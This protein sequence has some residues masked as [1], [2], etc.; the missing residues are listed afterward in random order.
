VAYADSGCSAAFIAANGGV[1]VALAPINSVQSN[2]I[3]DSGIPTGAG[4]VAVN[5]WDLPGMGQKYP[6]LT[7]KARIDQPWGHAS[8]ELAVAEE[9]IKNDYTGGA[10]GLGPGV[11]QGAHVERW[12]YEIGQSGHFNTIGRDKITWL[13]SYAQGAADYNYDL[14]EVGSQ[15]EEG[16]V[17]S[18]VGAGNT[19][20][21]FAG[22]GAVTGQYVCSQPR[23]AG[24]SAGYSHWWTDELRSG[25]S[26]GYAVISRPNAAQ[27]WGQPNGPGAAS[28]A[29]DGGGL[30]S[31][32][33]T[34]YTAHANI[35]WTPVPAAQFG[36]EF[37]WYRRVVQS[38]ASGT[39]ERIA[40]QSIFKF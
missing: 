33:K 8:L 3:T 26:F 16:L 31:L 17:C 11:P 21:V 30:S 20:S 25:V 28:S 14:N 22:P 38:G 7:G 4:L 19:A 24:V 1:G 35:L 12:G 6:A 34:H 39:H 27:D 37:Q 13:I 29:Q 5:N 40:F 2:F 23:V 10:M 36:L 32:E 9:R 15:W 18:A